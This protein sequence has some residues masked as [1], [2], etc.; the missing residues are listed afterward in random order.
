MAVEPID[1]AVW[2]AAGT[3]GLYRS[4]DAGNSW[5]LVL[6]T[7]DPER[8]AILALAVSAAD[9]RLLYQARGPIWPATGAIQFLRSRDSGSTWERHD[10]PQQS[11]CAWRVLL[12][13]PHPTDSA[14]VFRTAGCYA[15]RDLGAPL[16]RS[17]DQGTTWAEIFRPNV[18]FPV[19]LVGGGAAATERFYLSTNRDFRAGGSTLFRS[20][21]GG[22]SWEEVLAYRGGGTIQGESAPN[23]QM[24]GLTY[25]RFAPDRVYVGLV[26]DGRGV[27]ASEDAGV[28][29]MRL[30]STE[31]GAVPALALGIDGQNLYA[32]TDQGLW[33]LRISRSGE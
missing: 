22:D 5:T 14:R 28:S 26:G 8:G 16:D 1:H 19:R 30:G 11:G 7:E 24:G 25:D 17:A 4:N 18:A 33:R 10:G 15:G 3:E 12:L 32:G 13:E 29:W 2:Y 27:Q 21:D 20:D 31:I 9:P 23:V 6:P